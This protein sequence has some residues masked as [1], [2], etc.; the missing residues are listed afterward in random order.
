MTELWADPAFLR[1]LDK[2]PPAEG[3]Q[4]RRALDGLRNHPAAHPQL[5]RLHGSNYPGSFRL[6]VGSHRVLGI[7]LASQDLVFLTTVFTKKRDSDYNKALTRHQ[8]RLAAQGPPL[9]EYLRDARRR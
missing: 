2:M 9:E 7:L 6:R 1:E 3:Q 5:V 8:T 4:V